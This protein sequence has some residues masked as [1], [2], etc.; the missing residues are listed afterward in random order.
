MVNRIT[1]IFMKKST[2]HVAYGTLHM[3]GLQQPVINSHFCNME[4]LGV[5]LL[6]LRRMFPRHKV[7]HHTGLGSVNVDYTQSFLS[8]E[9]TQSNAAL[10]C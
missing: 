5:L 9:V 3:N 6:P 7:T 1:T 10:N 2:V 4:L 8:K